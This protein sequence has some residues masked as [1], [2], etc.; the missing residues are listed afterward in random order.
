[1]TRRLVAF[2][3]C[4]AVC[5]GL[6]ARAAAASFPLSNGRTL[7]GEPISFT[8]QGMVVKLADGTFAE[9]VGWTNFTQEALKVLAKNPKAKQ[10]VEPYL[11]VEETEDASK[12]P[13]VEVK[14]AIPDRLER[15]D[16]KAGFSALFTSSV[17]ITLFLLLYAANIYAAF[18]IAIFRNYP[19]ALVCGVAAVV[20]VLGPILF[21]CL[22]TRLQKTQDELAAESMAQH[23]VE[24]EGHAPLHVGAH[25]ADAGEQGAAPP[26]PTGPAVTVYSRGQTT[27]NR[28]FFETKF[29]GFLRVVPG[30]AERDMI[31]HIRSARGEYSGS[32]LTRI[33]PNELCLQVSKGGATSDVMIPFTEIMEIQVRHKDAVAAPSA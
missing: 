31:I 10:F 14:A 8:A 30:E 12:K 3:A 2:L 27:F 24:A 29:A 11:E 1:M 18:E 25:A 13:A 19:A 23:M 15:P 33:M 4:I 32:R 5:A 16:P 21:I 26:V 22:P 17:T 7:E 28:R 20:P 6:S 9:R